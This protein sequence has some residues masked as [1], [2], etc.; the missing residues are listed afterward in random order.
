M[1]VVHRL[2]SVGARVHDQPKPAPGHPLS[3]GQHRGGENHLADQRR[4][5]RAQVHQR[6]DVLVGDDQDVN[7]SLGIDVSKGGDPI[8][9]VDDVGLDLARRDLAEDAHAVH[10]LPS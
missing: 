7:G 2:A 3:L 1:D 8:V 5:L 6:R 10:S 4:V 9:L